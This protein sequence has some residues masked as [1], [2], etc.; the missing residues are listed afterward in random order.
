[1]SRRG[2]VVV[3]VA[4]AV[5]M[6]GCGAVET[7][8]Q[9]RQ[10]EADRAA[11]APRQL[12]P[13]YGIA[14]TLPAG[15]DGWLGRGA[16]H[17]ASFPLPADAPGWTRKAAERFAPSDVLVTIFENEPRRSPPLELAEY[18]EL[19]GPLRLDAGDFQ[20]FDGITEDSRASGHGYARRTFQLSGRFFV[21][22]AEAGERVPPSAALA[23]LNDLL[24][25]LGVDPGD[26]YPGTVAPARFPQR[27]GWFVG[28]G[29]PDEA[30]AEGEFTT[31]WASTGPY[32]DEWNALPPFKTLRR[33]PRDGIIIWVGLSRSNRFPPR[34]EGDATFPTRE[35]PFSLADFEARAA[36]EGQ[37]R[38]LPEYLLLATVRGQY[39]LDLRVYFGRPEPSEEMR[40]QAQAMLD[41]LELPDWGPWE[42][43]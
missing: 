21:L 36:W 24:A 16:L 15:W 19:D 28:T 7:P 23:A 13:R 18:P 27:S 41:R 38:D 10:V 17:A 35:P 1:V 14:V 37:V 34:P 22:F 12:G 32:A 6:S 25:S 5:L 9:A 20:P 8:E 30:R 43:R 26:F 11:D 31:A 3:L 39:N 4:L 29:G 40:S 42:T 2:R 33:L